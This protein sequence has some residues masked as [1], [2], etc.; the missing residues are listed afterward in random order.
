MFVG[1]SL[2]NLEHGLQCTD[3]QGPEGTGALEKIKKKV[4][5]L[6]SSNVKQCFNCESVCAG[7]LAPG[8]CRRMGPGIDAPVAWHVTCRH[9][10]DRRGLTACFP[11][12]PISVHHAECKLLFYAFFF[13]AFV[14]K[15]GLNSLLS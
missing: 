4:S 10:S 13:M 12:R 5:F 11:C 7:S 14:A 9:P 6:H 1:L 3:S 8:H 2:A 15:A